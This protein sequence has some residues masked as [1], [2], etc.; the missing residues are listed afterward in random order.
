MA[1]SL[2]WRGY[3]RVTSTK[4]VL[5][6][7]GAQLSE[8]IQ[9]NESRSIHGGGVGTVDGRFASLHNYALGQSA[10]EGE[11]RG[12]VFAG[13]G[14]YGNAFREILYR[15]I[16]QTPSDIS[17]R[18]D[19]FDA[20]NPLIL[21]PGGGSEWL[22]PKVGGTNAKAVVS[23]MSLSA[24]TGGNVEFSATVVSAGADFNASAT[25]A[26]AVT[27]FAYEPGGVTDD[28]NPLPY[29][30]S[31]FTV[32]GSGET[33]MTERI[34]SWSININNNSVPIYTFDGNNY[35]SDIL[36]G[37]M[38][39]SGSFE[40]Y[41]PDGTFVRNLTHGATATLTFGANTI[42]LPHL[43]FGPYPV[44]LPGPN[45]PTIRTVQFKAFASST[46]PSIY[47]A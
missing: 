31:A 17:A 41:S 6:L 15:A 4:Y 38:E 30:A 37:M 45:D 25:N 33:G 22:F 34:T 21:S 44:P 43:A 11:L 20:T 26:P 46:H 1:G 2:G 39:I 47:I 7:A 8:V 3:C 32:T 42:T 5:P 16:G 23:S 9:I 12:E 40:Y 36:Q 27:D 24:R 13:T 29:Y 10:C 19:G 18:D 28:S 14:N 35:P